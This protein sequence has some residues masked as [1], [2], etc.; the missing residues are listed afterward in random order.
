MNANPYNVQAPTAEELGRLPDHRSAADM[1]MMAGAIRS[2]KGDDGLFFAARIVEQGLM[3]F[4]VED[5]DMQAAVD[6]FAAIGQLGHLAVR[7]F[8]EHPAMLEECLENTA[9]H[10]E[11]GTDT[12]DEASAGGWNAEE[13]NSA[14]A[15]LYVAR[16]GLSVPFGV[17][18]Q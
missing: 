9:Q 17:N 4:G 2:L 15:T 7:T 16:R 14:Y 12:T 1:H 18:V 5:P 3:R 10:C 6:M 13:V 8:R 11:S